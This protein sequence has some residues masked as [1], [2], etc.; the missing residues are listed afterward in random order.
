MKRFFTMMLALALLASSF[1]GCESSSGSSPAAA[2]DTAEESGAAAQPPE[3]Q[4]PPA[5]APAVFMATEPL[6]PENG[7]GGAGGGSWKKFM[8]LCSGLDDLNGFGPA[9]PTKGPDKFTSL[10]VYRDNYPAGEYETT[11]EMKAGYR[12]Q[13]IDFLTAT[14]REDLVEAGLV[15]NEY[16]WNEMDPPIFSCQF[17]DFKI[18]GMASGFTLLLDIPG[19][20]E[21][22]EDELEILFE[23]NVFLSQACTYA[24]IDTPSFLSKQ[25]YTSDGDATRKVISVYQG[26]E[27]EKQAILNQ[28]LAPIY[29][30]VETDG[31]IVVNIKTP[32]AME[33]IG[34]YQL[35]PYNKALNQLRKEQGVQN[36]DVLGY[37][38]VYDN[39]ISKGYYV[40]YYKFYYKES[41]AKKEKGPKKDSDI[42][43][44][45]ETVQDPP[46]LTTYSE[47][48]IRA[49]Q[50]NE[51]EAERSAE[52]TE[53]PESSEPMEPVES[54]IPSESEEASVPEEAPE[55][56]STAEEEVPPA[57]EGGELS[58]GEEQPVSAM[59]ETP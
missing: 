34:D 44:E 49:V 26:T 22:Q 37:R 23:E 45:R 54:V 17:Q 43:P 13:V 57:A 59:G 5:E 14:G 3:G 48:S 30:T 15:P 19:I 53:S 50:D 47:Y 52:P 11:E 18:S 27:D 6:P 20:K 21:M 2:S 25:E 42:D 39:N 32:G 40:P 35:L 29:L 36:K 31:S 33:Y 9:L 58:S 24:G 10:P 16:R 56:S 1:A 38:L 55:H 4:E 41:D 46:G 7:V 12:Q 8:Y 28:A 51:V